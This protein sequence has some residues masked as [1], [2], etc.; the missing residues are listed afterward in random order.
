MYTQVNYYCY[1]II[2]I[3]KFYKLKQKRTKLTWNFD[4]YTYFACI[5]ITPLILKILKYTQNS[6][7]FIKTAFKIIKSNPK[8]NFQAIYY[9]GLWLSP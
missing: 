7:Y 4:Q 3:W 2:I 6:L 9:Q 8:K 5:F 1:Y